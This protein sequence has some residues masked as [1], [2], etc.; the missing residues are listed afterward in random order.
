MESP[1]SGSPST[2]IKG[3]KSYNKSLNKAAG[4][5]HTDFDRTLD[6]E[7]A[8]HASKLDNSQEIDKKSSPL[9]PER[10]K[11]PGIITDYCHWTTPY[12]VLLLILMAYHIIDGMQ[13]DYTSS[14]ANTTSMYKN[15]RGKKCS[16]RVDELSKRFP[17][18]EPM[19]WDMIDHELLGVQG[20]NSQPSIV[21]FL[22][23]DTKVLNN[24][25]SSI[26][27]VTRKCLESLRPSREPIVLTK[28]ELNR[29]ADRGELIEKYKPQLAESHIM[30]VNNLQEISAEASQSFHDFCDIDSPIVE[31]YVVYFTLY[32]SKDTTTSAGKLAREILSKLWESHIPKESADALISR[33]TTQAAFLKGP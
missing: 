3:R 25:F 23:N 19:F 32:Y 9:L 2:F 18:Q 33:I 1:G 16:E 4:T 17:H 5:G 13:N 26:V 12:I 6:S 15:V 14:S 22:Y 20:E 24:V 31:R 29:H 7:A 27:N 11:S 10:Q 21:T 30:L 8:N 28:E